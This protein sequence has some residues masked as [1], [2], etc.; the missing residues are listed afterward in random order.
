MER[1]MDEISR[2]EKGGLLTK[3]EAV[4]AMRLLFR[5][6]T[7]LNSMFTNS[8]LVKIYI[9]VKSRINFAPEE[10]SEKERKFAKGITDKIESLLIY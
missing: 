5:D 3:D 6:Y 4:L 9:D 8:E 7:H 2:L 10:I 1:I